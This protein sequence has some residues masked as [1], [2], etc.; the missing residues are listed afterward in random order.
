[1]ANDRFELEGVVVDIVRG[2][3]FMVKLNQNDSI[4]E[5][6]TSGKLKQNY[7]KIIRG[8]KVTVDISPYDVTKGR[9]VWRDK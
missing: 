6:T 7:I 9:I 5:C 8:D 2:G 1:M 3:K 4:I